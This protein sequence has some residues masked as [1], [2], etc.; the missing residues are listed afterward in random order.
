[1]GAGHCP[2]GGYTDRIICKIIVSIG[3]LAAAGEVVTDGHTER[4]TDH[5]YGCLDIIGPL[6]EKE[7]LRAPDVDFYLKLCGQMIT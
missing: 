4:I 5:Y 7:N 2:W 3:P 1:M 6:I